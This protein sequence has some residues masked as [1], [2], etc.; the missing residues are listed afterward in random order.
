MSTLVIRFSSLGDIVLTGAV[1][2]ALAPVS[3]LT[4]RLYSD[5]AAALPG[6]ERVYV[7][8]DGWPQTRF[9]RIIDLHASA[10]SRW[11][12][13][14][15][16]GA[17]SRI[18]RWDLRRRTR[19]AFK[20]QPAP[21][22]VQRYATAAGIQ[23]AALPY[24]SVAGPRDMLLLCPASAHPTKQWAAQRF[25]AIGRRW[26]ESGGACMLLG[27]EQEA[28]LLTQMAKDIGTSTE[29]LAERGFKE[30]LKALGRGR[31]ALGGDAGLT[32]LCAAAGIPTAVLLGP[33][34]SDDG[35]WSHGGHPI[36]VPLVCRP[37]SRHGGSTCAFNDHECMQ[38]LSIDA[39]WQTL[40]ALR[41][42]Q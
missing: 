13:M 27:S 14:R 34:T 20:T 9:D 38:R 29:V 35:F 2:G 15:M 22:V 25:V 19:V 41:D 17:V 33:T 4:S 28:P 24:L 42:G 18:E 39:V 36:E 6:V 30:T 31:I 21:S 26:N 11:A 12:T 8:E 37:C 1:T 7:R 5:V 16:H 3:F 10:R 40:C 32:H 23:P